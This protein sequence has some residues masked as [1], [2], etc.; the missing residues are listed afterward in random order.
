MNLFD[1]ISAPTLLIAFGGMLFASVLSLHY[2]TA[3]PNMTPKPMFERLT[4]RQNDIVHRVV[5]LL[6]CVAHIIVL[7]SA[8]E[9]IL[10]ITFDYFAK[11]PVNVSADIITTDFIVG[12]VAGA[13]ICGHI[14]WLLHKRA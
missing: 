1:L 5:R 10:S 12:M 14:A 7:W 9:R 3:Y 6:F 8:I 2:I 13:L 11:R 4:V